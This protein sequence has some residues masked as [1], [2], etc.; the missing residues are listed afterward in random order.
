MILIVGDSH[1]DYNYI[2]KMYTLAIKNRCEAIIIAGDFGYWPDDNQGKQFL[3]HLNQLFKDKEMKLYFVDG[4]HEDFHHIKKL[5][6]YKVSEVPEAKNVFYIPRGI[7]AEIDDRKIMGFGGA[8]SIDKKYRIV[9][10]SWFK[11]E[12]ITNEHIKNMD[13]GDIDILITHD[14]PMMPNKERFKNDIESHIHREKIQQICMIKEPKMLVHGHY[15]TY[16]EYL[17]RTTNCI[18]LADN[19][20][21]TEKQFYLF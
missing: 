1:A 14:A 11:E 7:I 18:A 12:Q 2:K 5:P 17:Y 8:V 9:D 19:T 4:N 20:N 21:H 10:K 16:Y 6:Q 13:K 15:H 3:W